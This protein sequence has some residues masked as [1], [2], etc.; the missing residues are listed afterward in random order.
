MAP[1][2]DVDTSMVPSSVTRGDAST[3]DRCVYPRY[4]RQVTDPLFERPDTAR[5][6]THPLAD[7]ITETSVH[8][9]TRNEIVSLGPLYAELFIDAARS[10]RRVVLVSDER[11]RLTDAF[12]DV[13]ALSGGRWVV[14][15]EADGLRDAITGRALGTIDEV[16]TDENGRLAP[17]FADLEL[18]DQT[19]FVVSA[20]VRH[21]ADEQARIGRPA[22]LFA[23]L[24]GASTPAGWGTHEPV[25]ERWNKDALTA[26]ARTRMPE[27]TRVIVVGR[28]DHPF[29]GSITVRRTE[30]GIE[31]IVTGVVGVGEPGSP[32]TE[33]A[34]DAAPSILRDL[35]SSALPLV[36]MVFARVG[37]RDLTTRPF[38][39]QDPEPV[40][41]LIGAPAVKALRLDVAE[42]V[43][44]FG[45]VIAGRPRVPALVFPLRESPLRRGDTGW[46][47]AAEIVEAIGPEAL[48]TQV[49]Q[50]FSPGAGPSAGPTPG[51]GRDAS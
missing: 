45:A 44:R 49:G 10:G 50:N 4:A 22:E 18:P 27:D 48:A 8:V 19:Q 12:R 25:E 32:E 46:A 29:V 6:P 34:F 3:R 51:G 14:R 2:V 43:R 40:A 47:R 39:R 24:G 17:A 41:L 5:P 38:L 33:R 20:S 13:L 31:E 37:R 16:L 15:T 35:C 1:L 9:E 21:R 11:T 7:G 26:F 36:A 28:P 23:G 42:Y 30:K